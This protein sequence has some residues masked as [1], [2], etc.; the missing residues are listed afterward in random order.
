M[1]KKWGVNKALISKI[2]EH[3]Q[4]ILKLHVQG[5]GDKTNVIWNCMRGPRNKISRVLPFPNLF[6]SLNLEMLMLNKSIGHLSSMI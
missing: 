6:T 2:E 5:I 4:C 1:H 3:V